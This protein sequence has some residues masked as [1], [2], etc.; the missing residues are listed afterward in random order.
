MKRNSKVIRKNY[1]KFNESQ[2]EYYGIFVKNGRT[3]IDTKRYKKKMGFI[4]EKMNNRN[5]VYYLPSKIERY[6]YEYNIIIDELENIKK[7]WETEFSKAISVIKTP[8]EVEENIRLNGI[9]DGVL[10]P[11]EAS[12]VAKTKSLMYE[13]KYQFVIRSIYVQ[14][15][16]Q[17]MSQINSLCLRICIKKGYNKENFNRLDFAK[18]IKKLSGN[19]LENNKY[20]SSFEKSYLVWNFLKHNSKKSYEQLNNKY[21]EMICDKKNKFEN[22]DLAL[23]YLNIDEKYIMDCIND[24]KLFFEQVCRED[25]CEDTKNANWDYDDYFLEQVYEEIESLNNPLGLPSWI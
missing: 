19:D 24:M 23:K 14:F 13:G 4:R 3:R 12:S 5:T 22:G 21:N 17:L 10:E 6:D 20:Y 9:T 11:G 18:I 16:H 15:F 1:D 7:L 8:K 2:K 25:F